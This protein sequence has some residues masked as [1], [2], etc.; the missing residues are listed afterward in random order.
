M[1]PSSDNDL[2]FSS[3][4][5]VTIIVISILH[6]NIKEF[7]GYFDHILYAVNSQRYQK[8]PASSVIQLP[9]E[10]ALKVG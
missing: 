7:H 3:E 1:V 4:A 5:I 6:Q 10:A 8:R 2:N 9:L